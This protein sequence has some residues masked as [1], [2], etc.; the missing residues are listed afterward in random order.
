MYICA[1]FFHSNHS[2]TVD[3]AIRVSLL[4]YFIR[5]GS[6]TFVN[7]PHPAGQLLKSFQGSLG[8]DCKGVLSPC[9]KS[10]VI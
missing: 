8:Y 6:L 1:Y 4:P 5:I 10:F 3:S 9:L 2:Y 7:W